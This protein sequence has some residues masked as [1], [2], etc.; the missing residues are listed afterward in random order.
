MKVLMIHE[1]YLQRGGEDESTDAEV[2]L[3][4]RHGHRVELLEE[5]NRR[6]AELGRVRTAVRAT[7]SQTAYREVRSRLR[8]GGFD[9]VHVQNF[10]PL[11]SPAVHW[12]AHAEGVPTV[13]SLRNYRLLC[14]NALL[15]RDG[16]PCED[17]VGRALPWPGVVHACYRDS[18]AASAAVAL[19]Q[20][21][22]RALA[23]WRRRVAV[24][25]ALSEFARDRLTA[26]GVPAD[27]L[28]VKP[29]FV[30]PD[31]GVGVGGRSFLYVGRLAPE[32]GVRTLLAAWERLGGGVPLEI[33]G[34]GP[35]AG[36][37]AAAAGRLAGVRW[38]GRLPRAE[39]VERMRA[40]RALVFPSEWYETFG[41]VA[42]EAFACGTPV[43]AS[44]LGAVA[45]LI[46]ADTG[47]LFAPGDPAALAARVSEL[48]ADDRL[49][50]RMR[51]AARAEFESKYD[52]ER[53]YRMLMELYERARGGGRTAPGAAAAEAG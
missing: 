25:V 47:L 15:F 41:R 29:N 19:S 8:G 49:A 16:G 45:E 17:C 43:I 2:A 50:A 42:I 23:T 22:H 28:C 48:A 51:A 3:L 21:A 30:D 44:R 10:F 32:K 33:V 13:Q 1:R 46:A 26:G 20:V 6:V 7:W 11:L 14:V 18:G 40:A 52:A 37:V 24:F 31:P 53:N 38:H 34:D 5:D 39:A 27:R 9:L 4:R 36:E 12:A 35:L